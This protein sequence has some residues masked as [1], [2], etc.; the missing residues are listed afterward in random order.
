MTSVDDNGSECD[1][2]KS[3]QILHIS[4]D[5]KK[6]EVQKKSFYS[7]IAFEEIR[8]VHECTG[9]GSGKRACEQI[10]LRARLRSNTFE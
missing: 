8:M 10:V 3:N 6:V 9:N 7:F 2:L 5:K 1:S 4:S